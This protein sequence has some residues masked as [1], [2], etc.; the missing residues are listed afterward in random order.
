M[1]DGENY[2]SCRQG[3]F[4]YERVKKNFNTQLQGNC[5]HMYALGVYVCAHL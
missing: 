4:H 3:V 1:L 2:V 5:E